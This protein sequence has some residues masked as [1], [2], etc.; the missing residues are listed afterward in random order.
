MTPNARIT[1]RGLGGLA[2]AAVELMTAVFAE[3]VSPDL[4]QSVARDPGWSA[5]GG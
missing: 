1:G 3:D 2:S 4:L 5:R